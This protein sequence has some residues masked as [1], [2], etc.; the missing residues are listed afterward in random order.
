MKINTSWSTDRAIDEAQF[1]FDRK[2]NG[3]STTPRGVAISS[4]RL[5]DQ[6]ECR[7]I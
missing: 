2:R 1:V 6:I 5:R 7:T 3:Y 4:E